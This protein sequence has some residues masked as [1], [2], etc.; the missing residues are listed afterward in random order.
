MIPFCHATLRGELRD[1]TGVEVDHIS[2]I[3]ERLQSNELTLP[4]FP[5]PA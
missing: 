4:L 1:H 3:V 5:N 2:Y